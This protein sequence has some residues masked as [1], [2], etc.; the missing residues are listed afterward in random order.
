[1]AD[2]P[3]EFLPGDLFPFNA[4]FLSAALPHL[5]ERVIL[6]PSAPSSVRVLGK[7][8]FVLAAGWLG[9]VGWLWWETLQQHQLR[10]GAF[11]ELYAA[12]TIAGG[13][14]PALVMAVIGWLFA[15]FAGRAPYAE[16]ERREWWHAFWWTL[17]PNA[18]LLVTVW[19]MLQE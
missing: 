5:H 19:V 9:A 2:Y 14:V 12:D 15:R 17:T 1:M 10:S 16:L 8:M 13:I 7:S 18:L 3:G 6:D 4:A 11:P